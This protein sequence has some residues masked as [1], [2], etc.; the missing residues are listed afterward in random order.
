M[1]NWIQENS[2]ALKG[3][4]AILIILT[5]LSAIPIGIVKLLRP[6]IIVRVNNDKSTIP[7]DLIKFNEDISR[8]FEW[9]I[10]EFQKI[11]EGNKKLAAILDNPVLK[12]LNNP[13]VTFDKARIEII[14]QSSNVISGLRIRVDRVFSLWGFDIKGTFLQ[15]TEA[16]KYM[17]EF[18]DE[19]KDHSVVFP[20]LPS[21]PPNSSIIISLFGNL[22]LLEPT[23]MSAGH[24][25]SLINIVE[26]EDGILIDFSNN[27]LKYIFLFIAI[28][29]IIL[30]VL[31]FIWTRVRKRVIKNETK[32][33]FYNKA[34]DLAN[35]GKSDEA[36]LVLK[37]AIE[38]GYVN[39]QHILKDEDLESLRERRDF[40]ELFDK[41]NNQIASDA[42]RS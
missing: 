25:Y 38:A 37:L 23:I 9:D 13:N 16:E 18:K 8:L 4:A 19:L 31:G 3:I 26:A 33:I 41:P 34:C 32:Y 27:P 39:R 11:K 5:T 10:D 22:E 20:E 35:A 36:M 14:N 7:S 40:I 29:P 1:W 6:D 12:R 42:N 28:I 17:S 24:S 2:P 30:L 15:E 21:L